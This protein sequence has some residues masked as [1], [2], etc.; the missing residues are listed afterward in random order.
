MIRPGKISA[1]VFFLWLVHWLFPPGLACQTLPLTGLILDH[2]TGKPVPFAQLS[3]AVGSIGTAANGEGRFVLEVPELFRNDTLRIASLGYRTAVVPLQGLTGADT[4]IRLEPAAVELQEVEVVALT[5]E[6]VIRRVVENIPRNYGADSVI[7]TAFVRSQ[8]FVGARTVE[9]AEAIIRD[10]KTGYFHYP[11]KKLQEKQ[12]VSNVP[13][14]VRGRVISDTVQVNALGEVGAGAGCLGCNFVS[15]FAEFYHQSVLDPELAAFFTFRMKEETGP[16]GGKL[17]HILF[18][19]KKGTRQRL[20]RGELYV[21]A[22]DFALVS[23]TQKPSFEGLGQYDRE[24]YQR[25]YFIAGKG[26]WYLEAPV[27][28]RTTTYVRRG[29]MWSLGT[30][31][32]KNRLS[33]TRPADG[34]KI[35]YSHQNDVVVTDVVR[36]PEELRKFRGD[37]TIGVSQRWD[38]I[39]GA[40]NNDFWRGFNYLPIE[41]RLRSSLQEL[42]REK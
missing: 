33:F 21:N 8:K 32:V 36:A 12:R 9:F 19:Q 41:E 39:V 23:V 20:W 25:E 16:G 38:E 42:L 17:Y 27:T 30:I 26:G 3:L 7:L 18:D 5:P 10:L 6:E 15:D 11:R 2:S 40:T 13:E 37:K 34:G 22:A 29:G 35:V 28:E 4:V 1:L 14:L 24:K 31:R